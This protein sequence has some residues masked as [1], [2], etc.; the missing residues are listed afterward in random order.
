MSNAGSPDVL[1][2]EDRA[3]LIDLYA[4]YAWAYDQGNADGYAALFAKDGRFE[5][6]GAPDAV[7]PEAL[8]ALVTGAQ[9]RGTGYLHV[10]SNVLVQGNAEGAS[11]RAYVVLLQVHPDAVRLLAA[12]HYVDSF[13]QTGDGWRI[14]HRR[15]EP[16]TG[17][18]VAGALIVGG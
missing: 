12:G 3:E 9:S 6:P 15:F 14:A 1:S 4:R 7:G 17:A 11:G 2:V 16:L 13:V 10:T 5:R 8:A 18:A